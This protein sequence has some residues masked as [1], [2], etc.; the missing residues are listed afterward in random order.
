MKEILYCKNLQVGYHGKAIYPELNFCLSEGD[1]CCIVGANGI[2]KSTLMKTI[3]GLLTPIK[4]EVTWLVEKKIAYVAQDKEWQAN[5]PATV[6]EVVLS[7]AQSR[8]KS[9]FY[10]RE[11]KDEMYALLKKMN[12]IDL[13]KKRYTSLSGGQ[14]QRTL[15]ARAI[16]SGSKIFLLDEPINGLDEEAKEDFYRRLSELHQQEKITV[17]MISHDWEG[18]KPYATKI[19]SLNQEGENA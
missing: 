12:L 17:L 11:I 5:F 15:L 14:K 6:E 10:S 19:L 2:G 7:G 9:F 4:G 1:Y 13:A 8:K 18:I 16:F 3:I